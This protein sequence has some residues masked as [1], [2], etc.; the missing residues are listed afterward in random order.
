[1]KK[2]NTWLKRLGVLLV[3]VSIFIAAGGAYVYSNQDQILNFVVKELNQ[4]LKAEIKVN[5]YKL[6]LFSHFP[7]V[8]I[9]FS[10]VECLEVTPKP[11]EQ[12][13]TFKSLYVNL[14]FW[15]VIQ[16]DYDIKKLSVE[17]GYVNIKVFK[18]GSNNYTFWNPSSDTSSTRIELSEVLFTNT[19]FYFFEQESDIVISAMIEDLSLNG[20]FWKEEFSAQIAFNTTEFNLAIKEDIYLSDSRVS[21]ETKF[22]TNPNTVSISNGNL[23]INKLKFSVNG[24]ILEESSEWNVAGSKLE[25]PRFIDAIPKTFLPLKDNMQ[26]KGLANVTTILKSDYNG[27]D[28]TSSLEVIDAS[29][30]SNKSPLFIEN[31]A[32]KATYSNGK[33]NNLSTSS[34]HIE[35]AKGKTQTGSFFCDAD[36][37]NFKRPSI[38]INGDVALNLEELMK[39]SK[40]GIFEKVQGEIKSSFTASNTYSSFAE[41]QTLA[42]SNA[43]FSGTMEL[44]GGFLKFSNSNFQLENISAS[45]GLN[46]KDLTIKSLNLESGESQ[47]SANGILT[48]VLHFGD[49]NLT[50]FLKL[51]INS[52]QVNVQEIANWQFGEPNSSNSSLP[53]N[54]ETNLSVNHFYWDGFNGN[55]L[56][57][58]VSGTSSNIIGSGLS[59]KSSEGLITGKF[60]VST[61]RNS[62]VAS[63]GISNL[64]ISK[65]FSEFKNFGQTD[66][67]GKNIQG[68]LNTSLDLKLR[69]DENWTLIPNSIWMESDLLIEN[70]ELND[71][72]PL[73]SLEAFAEK[74]DLKHVQFSTLRNTIKI[75]NSRIYIPQM[76]IASN[77]LNLDIE[78][79]HYFNSKIDYS[80]RLELT[81]VLAGGK[82]PK[83]GGYDDFV[84]IE[85]RPSDIFIWVKVGCN[86]ENPCTG[87]DVS[88]MKDSMKKDFKSQGQELKELMK[89]D[90]VKTQSTQSEY[91]FEW[92]EE[93]DTNERED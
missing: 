69:F 2:K 74:E 46:G 93:P 33:R 90:T 36:I 79:I 11:N 51:K 83:S 72:K 31:L 86:V 67:T 80:I 4:S 57:G 70:G 63:A 21:G 35:N 48:K 77:A 13:F 32:F 88:K 53:F 29:Y 59:F 81:K 76:H 18:D 22:L 38:F 16:Q 71:Y 68:N 92:S 84:I 34:L 8:S 30:S 37:K 50:P 47:F 54:F 24:T 85:D 27:V 9:H 7:E 61:E 64:E 14:N 20:E 73:E 12:L 19:K 43:T 49:H 44:Q 82:K 10:D 60:N 91:I 28:I 1:M 58:K 66:L 45:L 39:I 5:T 3:L 25:L 78:G 41:I 65:L 87:L 26:T 17:D 42:L 40:P 75:E 55:E 23:E 52:N 6:D 62:M 15:D 89:K 56:S